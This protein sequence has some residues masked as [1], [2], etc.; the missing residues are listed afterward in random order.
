MVRQWQSSCRCKR[1]TRFLPTTSSRRQKSRRAK[2]GIFFG[3]RSLGEKKNF[4]SY[5]FFGFFPYFFSRL[6]FFLFFFQKPKNFLGEK[7]TLQRRG[8]D[9]GSF[10]IF[11]FA[12]GLKGKRLFSVLLW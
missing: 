4:F 11:F 10:D 9:C 12:I 2:S 6:F 8:E 5:F 7:L 1:R 3:E